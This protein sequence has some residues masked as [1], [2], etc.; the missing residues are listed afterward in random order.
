MFFVK[1][2]DSEDKLEISEEQYYSIIDAITNL[3][4]NY[5]FE[6][7]FDFVTESYFDLQ[8]CLLE[9][10]LENSLFHNAYTVNEFFKIERTINRM[11]FNFISTAKLYTDQIPA[12]IKKIYPEKFDEVKK[13]MNEFYEKN[14]SNKLMRALRNY[15]QHCG[16]SSHL[17]SGFSE[18]TNKE[19]TERFLFFYE[20]LL[21]NEENFLK[22]PKNKKEFSKGISK[23]S[24]IEVM[25]ILKKYFELLYKKHEEIRILISGKKEQFINKIESIYNN[26]KTEFRYEFDLS[27]DLLQIHSDSETIVITTNTIKFI[28]ELEN[29]NQNLS[30]VSIRFACNATKNQLDTLKKI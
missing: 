11:M 21:L 19:R 15:M 16:I 2:F 25:N 13:G 12:Y 17:S 5:Y 23:N 30:N 9:K 26:Y 1:A 20:T 8:K 14:F 7:K 18:K 27:Q 3:H 24:K 29:K 28:K 10:S 4:E 22:E 6:V